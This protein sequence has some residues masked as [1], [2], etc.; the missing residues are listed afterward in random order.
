M[1]VALLIDDLHWADTTTLALLKHVVAETADLR[2]LVLATYRDSEL[3][4]DHP[5]TAVLAD[6]RREQ[7]IERLRLPGLNQDE[8][9]S[10]V[11]DASGSDANGTVSVLAQ[12]ITAETGGNPFF[13]G[14]MLRH[15]SESEPWSNQR[16]RAVS[17][18]Q[19]SIS[20][21]PRVSGRSSV[22]A[23]SDSVRTVAMSALRLGYRSPLRLRPACSRCP[24]RRGSPHRSARRCCGGMSAPRTT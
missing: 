12:Q 19:R 24:R 1:P 23:W 16:Q 13:V 22:V 3:S 20:D 7:R 10:L 14:E 15:L 6:L 18:V 8:V 4:P 17:R 9:R 2:L 21:S 11:E 5:L